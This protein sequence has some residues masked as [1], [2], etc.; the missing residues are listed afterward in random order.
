MLH[1]EKFNVKPFSRENVNG[2]SFRIKNNLPES[3]VVAANKVRN[4]GRKRKKFDRG[5]GG[6]QMQ[7][8]R[9]NYYG[10]T[11]ERKEQKKEEKRV[12]FIAV[13]KIETF[14]YD[15]DSINWYED[16]ECFG[17]IVNDS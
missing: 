1:R 6:R 8:Q 13:A 9:K 11:R 5:Q 2:W 7:N 14:Y 3:S 15:S 16:L 17:H 10:A 12:A 4:F